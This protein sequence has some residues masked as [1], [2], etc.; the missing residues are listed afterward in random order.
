MADPNLIIHTE[1]IANNLLSDLD[2][3]EIAIWLRS[4]PKGPIRQS[5]LTSVLGLPWQMV[6]LEFSDR[7]LIQNLENS[8]DADDPMTRKR[9]FVQIIDG[10][11]TQIELPER[12]L[13]IYLLNGRHGRAQDDFQSL[14]RRMAM[15]EVL[16]RSRVSQILIISGGDNPIPPGLKD[17]WLSGFRSTLTF[18][19]DSGSASEALQ[20]WVAELDGL[21]AVSLLGFPPAQILENIL[22]RYSETYPEERCLI[23]MRDQ[24]GNIQAVDITD[25]DEPERPIL[26]HYSVVEERDLTMLTPDQLSEEEFVS[27]FQNPESSW[28]PYAAGLPWNR[29]DQSM[30]E[31]GNNLKNLDTVG[32]EENCVAY[33]LAEPGAGGT[34]SARMLA[35]SCACQG[36]PVLVAKSLPFA[37]TALPVA[38][39]MNRVKLR[40]DSSGKSDPRPETSSGAR[41]YETPWIIVFDRVHWEYN[42]N[43]LHRFR[44]QM[45][46]L[47]RS[48]CLLVVSGPHRGLSYFDTSVFR[49]IGELNHVVSQDE[50]RQLGQHLNRFLRHYGKARAVWQWDHFYREH[51]VRYL[52]GVSTFWVSLSFWIRGQYDLSES[53]QEWMY[54]SF[55]QHTTEGIV[56]D[57]ILEIAAMSSERLPVPEGLLPMSEDQWPTSQLLEDSQMSLGA[58]GLFRIS[59][60]GERYWGLVHDILGRFLINALFHD[61]PLRAKLGFG[62]AKDPEHLRFLL[63]KKI[64]QKREL[65]ERVYKQL[66]ED[67]ATTIFKIDPD[68][69]YASF[70][71]HWQEVLDALDAMASP[72]RDNS[73]VFRHH[74]AVSRRRV[75]KL[76]EPVYG[77]TVADKIKLLK[78]AITD[79]K[80]A[81]DSIEYTP[82]SE[83]NLNL[84]NSLA[85]AYFDLAALERRR[86]GSSEYV[87]SL[88]NNARD[89]TRRAYEESPTNSFVIETYVRDLLESAETSQEAAIEYCVKALV[90]LF[91]AMS[92]NEQSYR[93]AKLGDYADRAIEIMSRHAPRLC[94]LG[95]PNN[96]I[97]VLTRAWIILA[98]GIDYKSGTALSALPEQNRILAIDALAH[99][100]GKGNMQVIRLTYDLICAT[101]EYDFK[102]QLHYLEQ[103]QGGDY[104]RTPQLRLEYGILLYQN[105]RSKEGD[106][107]FRDLRRLWR[108]S[109]HFVS[110]PKPLRWLRDNT[111][112]KVRTVRAFVSSG[113]G[114]RSMAGVREFQNL[115]VP[116][117]A[118]EFGLLNAQ[119]GTLFSARVSFGHNGPLLR[120]VTSTLT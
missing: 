87:K 116:F 11:P 50:A 51:T 26:E 69:G 100:T 107:V 37:P 64:S 63:L 2:Q 62:A 21:A 114:F 108:E 13:P 95:E 29:D 38:N 77:V 22:R 56:Q 46:K 19:T 60:G 35:W 23:R 66:G 17:L 79:I 6:F 94:D 12:C 113:Y 7:E 53:I 78:R 112:G 52:E 25:L 48:V 106:S 85:H 5:V 96:P 109:E 72:L 4:P 120:P 98:E 68:H 36:Y 102:R 117:R 18:A 61:F 8:G 81:L 86:G 28:R 43:E 71:L 27:F 55:K 74:S 93:R 92:S 20:T 104:R 111:N 88:R 15:L 33:V 24:S 70:A 119:P 49:Q 30:K 118:E 58:L 39:F 76:D 75:A 16:R 110:V 45:E 3:R 73:R 40:F 65:G 91:S 97:D 31:L 9:G 115:L 10:D 103:L 101:Y 82:G 80:Y 54:R 57:A 59:A 84:Y 14:F 99:S 67:F 44:N 105:Y 32:P 34:T 90:I 83:P 47:G 1:D 89:A 42:D 41:H